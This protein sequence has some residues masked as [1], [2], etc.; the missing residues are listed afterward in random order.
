MMRSYKSNLYVDRFVTIAFYCMYMC[1]NFVHSCVWQLFLKTK[2]WDEI[3]RPNC[4][5]VCAKW[6]GACRYNDAMNRC[7]LKPDID[8][9][10]AGDLTEVNQKPAVPYM[11]S[12]FCTLLYYLV[13]TLYVVDA[14]LPV[15]IRL[16]QSCSRVQIFWL[17]PRVNPTLVQLWSDLF[18][19]RTR[20]FFPAH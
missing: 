3:M 10:P 14:S 9:L 6:L 7:S 16:A 5:V 1:M 12:N 18:S 13:C 20:C 2:R 8:M 17:D 15:C 19:R 4:V 11:Y